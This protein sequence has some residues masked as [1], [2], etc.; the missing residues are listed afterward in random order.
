MET[1]RA[2]APLPAG[3]RPGRSD[4][5]D[6]SA[7]RR[8]AADLDTT[9]VVEAAAGT[10]KTTALVSR[11]V[12]LVR[13]GRANMAGIA[14]ITFTQRAAG[15][16]RLRIRQGLEAEIAG[17]AA[18]AEARRMEEAMGAL[19]EASIGTIHAFCSTLLRE[20][21]LP[22]GV[23]PDFEILTG[24]EQA[25]FFEPLFREYLRRQLE[26]PAPGVAR[27]LRRNR[28]SRADPV[29]RLRSAAFRLL[30]HRDLDAP[31]S[32]PKWDAEEEVRRL[33]YEDELGN[34]ETAITGACLSTLAGVH[35]L[36]PPETPGQR[37]NWLHRSM[38]DAAELERD[39]AIRKE[40]GRWDHDWVEQAL[41][42]LQLR[43]YGGRP[44]DRDTVSKLLR[45][46]P[47]LPVEVVGQGMQVDL[48]KVRDGFL[49][50]LEVFR[51]KVG[52]DLAALLREDLRPLLGKYERTTGGGGREREAA[53]RNA[54]A[55]TDAAAEK[56]LTGYEEAKRTAGR[57]DFEDLLLRT[58]DLLRDD[59]G[60]REELR[61]RF[62]H[63]LV[64]EYQD[65]DPVQ[66]EILFLLT[67]AD[68]P[69]GDW[70]RAVPTPGRLFLVGDPKQSI[71]R[72]RRADVRHYL[73]VKEHLLAR[74][75]AEV[76]LTTNFRSVPGICEFVNGVFEPL[77][78]AA[79]G[80]RAPEAARRV[81]ESES[82][83][84]LDGSEEDEDD[85]EVRQVEY[86]PIEARRSPLGNQAAL[87]A[88]PVPDGGDIARNARE[89][90]RAEPAAVA[91]FVR[92]L[93]KSGLE[94]SDRTVARRPVEPSDICLLFR[95]F[96]AFG[97]LIPQAYA[98]A[99]QQR[100]I[101]QALA[102]IPS[103]TSST[104][105]RAM[106][107][108]LTAVEYPDDELQVYATLRGPLFAFSDE[109]LFLYRERGGRLCPG[110]P[111][112]PPET[113]G[114]QPEVPGPQP[115][116]PGPQPEVPGPQPE[117]ADASDRAIRDSLDFLDGLHRERNRRPV[118]RTIQ[119]LLSRHRAETAFAFRKS[120]DQVLANLRRL[121]QSAR[122]FEAGGGLSFRAFV[123]RLDDEANDA[124]Y[125]AM[126]AF[127][128]DVRGVRFSTVHSAK[129]LEFPVVIL[130]D[131]PCE[132]RGRAQ[133]VARPKEKLHAC[134]LGD[135]ILPLE[136][137]RARKVEEQ[138]DVLETDRTL[139][140]AATRA[141]DLL[142]TVRPSA[143]Y[144][145]DKSWLRP[146]Y[147]RIPEPDED[148]ERGVRETEDEAPGVRPRTAESPPADPTAR[149][150]SLLARGA[151]TGD[152]DGG[153]G[154]FLEQRADTLAR[155]SVPT[156]PVIRTD[157][158][159]RREFPPDEVAIHQLPRAP[160]RPR[161]AAFGELV[162]RILERAPFDGAD[163]ETPASL[164]PLLAAEY[165]LDEALAA[166][167]AAAVEA[168]LDHEVLL[169]ARRA[170]ERGACY[171]EFP[172][173]LREDDPA[174]EEPGGPNGAGPN[175][176]ET[177]G[178]LLVEGKVDLLF[179]PEDDDP[180][181]VVEFKTGRELADAATSPEAEAALDRYRR[182]A[183]IYAR[184]VSRATGEPVQPVLLFV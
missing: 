113:P 12:E 57:L 7:R 108:A 165:D 67:A 170:A 178:A 176:A 51:A 94:V 52:A 127:D 86:A 3:A 145:M 118:S 32:R 173:Y 104:E 174:P 26:D 164:A 92:G 61:A 35:R 10:G 175:G 62:T 18:P 172:I 114:P 158:Y 22:A 128:P 60:A 169:G 123:R 96:R 47:L 16:L 103:Y 110:A 154:A 163:E 76:R 73:Q 72:F 39:I 85:R 17:G 161:G 139:Y 48:N 112:P 44:P 53:D 156:E 43:E 4:L 5:P 121:T 182:Q 180:W 33:L 106:R 171:R 102:A 90:E 117:D 8:I 124:D 179:Q 111:G 168:A 126:H 70:L 79:G 137:L 98:D 125:G 93:L 21:P 136:L 34:D 66:T 115:E 36:L 181:M 141:R 140:V 119:D 45:A 68:P 20:R 55:E 146:V 87:A 13:S 138:E 105:I 100:D 133:R 91:R 31:W 42:A 150:W 38:A 58:R 74:G 107:A 81:G 75:A 151:G 77:F 89:I 116:V 50:R 99:L 129:G 15:D 109:E 152:G 84:P 147:D 122:E 24:G 142:V 30:E 130:V 157:R 71:Y 153:F 101:P 88:I 149:R 143:Q 11:V 69:G 132:R 177:N 183:T 65:T 23:D 144:E 184:A 6:A 80:G 162:H 83:D 167:A 131:T 49:A 97:R 25:A 56:A 14:A 29:R 27:L 135:G 46:F 64:D 9:L 155:G 166:P 41:A 82:G 40:A 54:T 120:A 37:P 148:R 2:A 28:D 160:G 1:A 134:D 159:A 95:R 78:G 63:I 19:E 59:P